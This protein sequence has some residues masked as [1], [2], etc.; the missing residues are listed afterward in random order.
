[1]SDMSATTS[2]RTRTPTPTHA[3]PSCRACA[4]PLPQDLEDMFGRYGRITDIR[5]SRDRFNGRCKGFAFVAMAQEDDV[6]EVRVWRWRRGGGGG[7]GQ[8][9]LAW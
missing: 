5:L 3:P 7:A 1:M 4:L 2:A 6:D 8:K 9:S